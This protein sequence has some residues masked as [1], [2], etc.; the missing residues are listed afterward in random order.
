MSSIKSIVIALLSLVVVAMAIYLFLLKTQDKVT[1]R[2]QIKDTK[3]N[4]IKKGE[5]VIYAWKSK[6][7]NKEIR[8]PFTNGIANGEVPRSQ[9]YVV[10]IHARG[11][12]L[13]SKV[14]WRYLADATYEMKPATILREF[15][16]ASGGVLK[17]TTKE[18]GKPLS[19][20][21]NKRLSPS[22][23]TPAILNKEGQAIGFDTDSTRI[24]LT[25]RIMNQ[26]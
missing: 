22:L 4:L 12:G 7:S 18:C 15:N 17:D 11:Y 23:F 21:L 5:V 26:P 2:A 25:S 14:Y 8:I 24:A 9:K 10:N 16:V 19:A 1:F 3:G 13:V 6:Q 20:R